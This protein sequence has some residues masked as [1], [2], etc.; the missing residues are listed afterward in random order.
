[1]GPPWLSGPVLRSPAMVD[2]TKRA[3]KAGDG[4]LKAGETVLAATNVMPTPLDMTGS[5]AIGGAIAGGLVGGLAGSVVDRHWGNKATAED[6]EQ[7]IP[8]MANR[9]PAPNAI[10]TNGAL[11]AVTGHRI[12]FWAISGLGRPK[13]VL[14]EVPFQ[15]IDA[16][17]W[18]EAETRWMRGSPASTVFWIGIEGETVLPAA[19]I[20]VGPAAKYVRAVAEALEQQLPGKVQEFSP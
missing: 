19:A 13:E 20:T 1:M 17:A 4:I 6:A 8:N 14:F 12:I 7:L 18:H 11:M 15:S 3:A 10:P 16:I 2:F 9:Q 5:A